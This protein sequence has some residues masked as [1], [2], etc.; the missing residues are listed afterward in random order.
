[1][2]SIECDHGTSTTNSLVY[3]RVRKDLNLE[4]E[5]ALKRSM[6]SLRYALGELQSTISFAKYRAMKK[7]YEGDS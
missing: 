6:A 3:P 4:D 1:M 2:N 5:R 7:R